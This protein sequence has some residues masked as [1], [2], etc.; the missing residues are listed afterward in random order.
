MDYGFLAFG[1][2][3]TPRDNGEHAKG[4]TPFWVVKVK[5]SMRIWSMLV[6]CKG[7]EDKAAIQETVES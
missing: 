2:E 4:A 5:P 3:P 6:Q 1:Q 7:V